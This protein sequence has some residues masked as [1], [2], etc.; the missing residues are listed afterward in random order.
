MQLARPDRLIVATMGMIPSFSNPVPVTRLPRCWGL[1]VLV[2]VLNNR[3]GA[4]GVGAGN[5]S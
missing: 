2:L 1:P 4:V 3:E 5:I